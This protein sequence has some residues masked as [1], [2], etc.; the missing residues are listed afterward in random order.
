MA[1]CVGTGYHRRGYVEGS[2]VKRDASP[3]PEAA[4]FLVVPRLPE[5]DPAPQRENVLPELVDG[6]VN[7]LVPTEMFPHGLPF[8]ARPETGEGIGFHGQYRNVSVHGPPK[9]PRSTSCVEPEH[10]P[11]RNGGW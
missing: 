9:S 11:F 6:S 7:G 2:F 3:F 5:I 10:G 8:R 4:R 1:S